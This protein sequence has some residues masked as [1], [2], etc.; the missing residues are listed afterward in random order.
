[1]VVVTPF[2]LG[3]ITF[4]IFA[5]APA[6]VAAFAERGEDRYAGLCVGGTNFAATAPFLFQ[7]WSKGNSLSAAWD[8][9]SNV[10]TMMVIYSAAGAGWLLYVMIPPVVAS[11]L[12]MTAQRRVQ[13]LR[14]IQRKL[15]EEWGPEIVQAAKDEK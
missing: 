10:L 9:L 2:F 13:T 1:V 7:L 8:Q 15:V 5:L 4:L 11:F 3:P 14:A 12:A 6:F